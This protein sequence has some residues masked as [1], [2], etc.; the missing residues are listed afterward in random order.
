MLQ[1]RGDETASVAETWIRE[2]AASP[3]F[4]FLHLFE[5]HTPYDPPAEIAARYAN[6]YDGEIAA[7]D[8]V[9]GRFFDALRRDG[10]YDSA[11]IIVLSD[12]GEG[13]GDHGEDEHGVL[14]YREALHV[15]L[16]VKLP[17]NAR[18]GTRVARPV[19]LIDV[20]PTV[21]AAT[22]ITHDGSLSGLNLLES[23]TSGPIYA[24]TMYPRIH[25]GWSELRSMIDYPQH[26]IDGPRPELYDLGSDFAERTDLV[27]TRRRE[28]ASLRKQLE[29]FLAQALVSPAVS[30]EEQARLASLG[31]VG[32]Q[33]ASARGSDLNPR[34]HLPD[35]RE[36]KAIADLMAKKDYKAAEARI[37]KLLARNPG[38]S[39]LRDQLGVAREAMGDLDGAASAYREAIAATP[40]LAAE[41]A[42]SLGAVLLRKGDLEGAEAHARIALTSNPPAAHDLLA[43]IAL[44]RGDHDG[45]L[46]EAAAVAQSASHAAA[47]E[48]LTAEI[49]L[50]R[51]DARSAVAALQQVAKLSGGDPS[52]LP[53][54][55][56]FA[57]GS[58]FERLGKR[59]DARAA[60]TEELES[61]PHNEAA[62]SALARL[63]RG[64]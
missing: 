13:L 48:L 64:V 63:S 18:A 41:F 20:F 5:P 36:L 40:E 19:Q 8:A 30:R 47:A 62:R 31:Y 59:A 34:D 54:G 50:A 33:G 11:M 15:P 35:L 45:A 60:Y 24:E 1:R 6:R 43:R 21:L 51:G 53:R 46:R 28:A 58:T 2:H 57:L 26:L 38:W 37:E 14:L 27:G 4:Y 49:H 42:L 9:L 17:R 52:R 61:D 32:G 3:F 10:I 29:P 39:D 55:Y 44:A 12:H 23:A 56:Y 22:G 7:T 16:F 25:L